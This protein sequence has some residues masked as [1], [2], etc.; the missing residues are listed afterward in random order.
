VTF[1]LTVVTRTITAGQ[2][3]TVSSVVFLFAISLPGVTA[4]YTFLE[5]G[6]PTPVLVVLLIVELAAAVIRIVIG[7]VLR[8]REHTRGSPLRA[9]QGGVETH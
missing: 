5:K 4:A 7:A 1:V 3:T 8:R 6:E 9:T 2:G